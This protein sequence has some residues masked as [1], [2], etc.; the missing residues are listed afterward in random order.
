MYL[1]VG[2]FAGV[3]KCRSYG[4]QSAFVCVYPGFCSCLW[5][6]RHPGLCRSVVPTALAVAEY[7]HLPKWIHVLTKVFTCTYWNKYTYLPKC[8]RVLT[9][10]STRTYQSVYVYLLKW[11]HVLTKVFTRTYWNEYTY[12]PKYLRVLTEMSTRTYRSVYVYLL[13]R[14]RRTHWSEYVVLIV[15]LTF[16]KLFIKK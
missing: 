6:S 13:K 16:M 7:T 8:L 12:L 9:E 5:H 15:T 3:G 1:S 10:M 2:A 14:V 4:A 11:I